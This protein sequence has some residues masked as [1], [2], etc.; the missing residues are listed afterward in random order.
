MRLGAV[1][2]ARPVESPESPGNPG[3]SATPGMAHRLHRRLFM[4]LHPASYYVHELKPKMP[5]EIFEPSPLRLIWLPIHLA[6]ISSGMLVIAGRWLPWPL[7]PVIS[8]VIGMSFGGLMFLGH[9]ALH[10]AIVRGRWNWLRPIVGWICFAP[11]ALSQQLWVVWHN[12]VHHAN[13]NKLDADPDMYPSLARYQTSRVTRWAIDNFAL[14]GRRKRGALS[15]LFGFFVQSK[16][17][18]RVGRSRLGMSHREYRRALV[19]TVL[20]IALWITLAALVGPVAFVF[21]FVIPLLIADVIVMGFIL[22]N[23]C[24]SPATDINDPLINALSVTAPRWI[25]W[26]TLEFGYHVEHHIFPSVCGRHARRVRQGLR[27]RWPERYQSMPVMAGLRALHRTGR[28][29]KDANTLVDP[30]SGGEWPTLMPRVEH[31]A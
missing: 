6:V 11:F 12:R 17:M 3:V 4:Q 18:L 16:D 7:I 20:A 28:I 29:Y 25:E 10:G 30:R 9:E 31:Q 13:T 8:L 15:L 14:G 24:L 5:V 2:R 21:A 26:V 23:H 22:T 19:E 27:E 1:H